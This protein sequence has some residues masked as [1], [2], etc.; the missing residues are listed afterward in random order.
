MDMNISQHSQ[1]NPPRRAAPLRERVDALGSRLARLRAV[2]KSEPDG[3]GAAMANSPHCRRSCAELEIDA[4]TI[5]ALAGSSPELMQEMAEISLQDFDDR[6]YA[7]LREAA[8]QYGTVQAD[9][10]KHNS[11][12]VSDNAL[13]AADAYLAH[14]LDPL[15]TAA[16]GA[17]RAAIAARLAGSRRIAA[18]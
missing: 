9:W 11:H 13:G 14:H 1:A 16:C 17:A 3:N 4:L 12:P 2:A 6:Y 8:G 10:C 15:R 18:F 7:V 5:R